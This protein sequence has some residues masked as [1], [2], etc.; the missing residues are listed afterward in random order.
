MRLAVLYTV[1]YKPWYDLFGKHSNTLPKNSTSRNLSYKTV[2][3][4]R[5]TLRI[6][7]FIA[8]SFLTDK[9]EELKFKFINRRKL[10]KYVE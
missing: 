8:A 7:M 6:K 4:A 10:Y 1:G 9:S 5:N 3:S 2:R